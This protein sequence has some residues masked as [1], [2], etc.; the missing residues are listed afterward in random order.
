M[1]KKSQQNSIKICMVGFFEYTGDARV[2]MYTKWLTD[3]GNFVDVVCKHAF[4]KQKIVNEDGARIFNILK[5]VNKTSKIRYLFTYGISFLKLC[6]HVTKL[7]FQEKY[8]FI[9]FHNIPDFLVFSGSL[10]K[11]FGARLILDI[12]DPMPEVYISKFSEKV[13]DLTLRLICFEEKISCAFSDGVITANHHF[14]NNLVKRGIQPEKI[15]IINNY[16]DPEIFKRERANESEPNDNQK[17][18]LIFPGTIAPRY[19]LD[20]AIKAIPYMI[21][22]I[23]NLC[24]RIIGPLGE[25]SDSLINLAKQL[26][27]E[28][29]VEFLSSVPNF[30]IPK[31][32]QKADIG[33]Y[34]ALPGPHMSIA[35]PGKILEFAA[36][37]L[38]IVSTR[39]KIVEEIFGDS[40]LLFFEPGNYKEFAHHIINIHDDPLLRKNLSERA[41]RILEEKFS[42]DQERSKYF[43]LI[44][45]LMSI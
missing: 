21:S 37:G 22:R 40:A 20:I 35:V 44:E 3:H 30:I 13:S 15:T 38:P 43:S 31:F 2:R 45:R 33:I 5:R 23:Q 42:H 28:E 1:T 18:T 16:P 39:L 34:P 10:P 6:F 12:H 17:F 25:C 4:S 26:E 24:L 32:L 19:G 11:I 7:Y 41:G 8:D 29:H 36:M 27:V 9:H 14:K